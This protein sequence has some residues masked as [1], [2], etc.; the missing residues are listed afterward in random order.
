MCVTRRSRPPP[1]VKVDKFVNTSAVYRAFLF[2]WHFV[3]RYCAPTVFKC[4]FYSWS[5][6]YIVIKINVSKL[7]SRLVFQWVLLLK[8]FLDVASRMVVFLPS[9]AS[10]VVHLCDV[11]LCHRGF[12]APKRTCMLFIMKHFINSINKISLFPVSTKAFSSTS[13]RR[14]GMWDFVTVVVVLLSI[15]ATGVRVKSLHHVWDSPIPATAARKNKLPDENFY[16]IITE[17]TQNDPLCGH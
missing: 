9:P 12:V 17:I 8:T 15:D 3:P 16:Y 7:R 5:H 13:R 11:H 2:I 1:S 14:N 6:I 10:L 4:I